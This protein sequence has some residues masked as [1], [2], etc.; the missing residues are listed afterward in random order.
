MNKYANL[1]F[2]SGLLLVQSMGYCQSDS[3]IQMGAQDY[4]SAVNAIGKPLFNQA[5]VDYQR[6]AAAI[7][8]SA[9]VNNTDTS[10]KALG[11]VVNNPQINDLSKQLMLFIGNNCCKYNDYR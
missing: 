7:T 2:A 3:A 9:I 5:I 1:C 8:Q 6:Q 10:G 4:R 11:A